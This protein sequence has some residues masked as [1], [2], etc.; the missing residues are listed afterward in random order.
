MYFFVQRYPEQFVVSRINYLNDI[1]YE[2]SSEADKEVCSFFRIAIG[3]FLIQL[4]Y[5]KLINMPG[6]IS[7]LPHPRRTVTWSVRVI[8]LQDVRRPFAFFTSLFVDAS[9]WNSLCYSRSSLLCEYTS[10]DCFAALAKTTVFSWDGF[11]RNA[12]TEA[13]INRDRRNW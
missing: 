7:K 4:A 1:I 2:P 6:R 13:S 8:R 9:F 5:G 3:R 10:A 11:V 12:G